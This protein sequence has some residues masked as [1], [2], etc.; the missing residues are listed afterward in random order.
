M[1]LHVWLSSSSV[2]A[3]FT[4]SSAM[5]ASFTAEQAN[6]FAE[7]L[8][9]LSAYSEKLQSTV[10]SEN[11]NVV[12]DG[13]VAIYS[14]HMAELKADHPDLYSKVAGITAECGYDSPESFTEVGDPVM[15]A[16]MARMSGPTPPQLA[17]MTPEM[18]A[19]M[20]PKARRGIELAFAIQDVPKDDIALITDELA[21]KID[22]STM[23]KK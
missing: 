19:S 9:P 1:R 16:Y 17:T 21:A 11:L 15:A 2:V 22:A 3:L 4:I 20:P 5:A 14:A 13:K 12:Q 10:D 7:C 6:Q 18:I 8:T 23:I